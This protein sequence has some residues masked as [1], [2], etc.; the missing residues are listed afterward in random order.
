MG[1]GED[2]HPIGR[3]TRHQNKNNNFT[4]FSSHP[5]LRSDG[6]WFC[7]NGLSEIEDA[8][9]KKRLKR[10]KSIAYLHVQMADREVVAASVDVH[11]SVAHT[12]V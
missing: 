2:I 6:R 11:Q 1:H 3:S 8:T 9:T 4:P 12:D 10:G 5:D 7:A